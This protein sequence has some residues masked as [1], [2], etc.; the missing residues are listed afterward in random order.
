MSESRWNKL[1]DEIFVREFSV[2]GIV[3]VPSLLDS[4]KYPR[5]SLAQLYQ[6]RW[7]VELDF[8]TI[9]THMSMEMLRCKTADRVNKEIAVHLLAY[10]LIRANLFRAACLND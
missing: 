2:D 1:P 6:Q 3:Y 4:K 10:N 8:R 5:N 7:K 9:K